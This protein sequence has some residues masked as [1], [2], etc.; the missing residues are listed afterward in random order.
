MVPRSNIDV[1]QMDIR[2][3]PSQQAGSQE[4]EQDSYSAC[5]PPL[6]GCLIHEPDPFTLG[7][8]GNPMK[9]TIALFALLVAPSAAQASDMSSLVYLTVLQYVFFLWP[10]VLPLFHLA[11]LPRKLPSYLLLVLITFGVLGVL[12]YPYVLLTGLGWWPA[13]GTY[14]LAVAINIAINVVA[15][16]ICIWYLPRFRK[17]LADRQ[18]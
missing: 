1:P 11:D 3:E 18:G 7:G 9:K 2:P 16:L 10:F 13:G 14:P 12:R 5:C 8:R 17:L 4:R 15:F 6:V